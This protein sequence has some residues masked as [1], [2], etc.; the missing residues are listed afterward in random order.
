MDI[1]ALAL[2]TALALRFRPR[3]PRRLRGY[4]PTIDRL[5]PGCRLR[6]AEESV[7]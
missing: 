5:R 3:R 4:V 6:N 7:Q 2:L 1:L